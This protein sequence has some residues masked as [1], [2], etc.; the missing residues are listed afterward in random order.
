[1]IEDN[2][3]LVELMKRKE[4]ISIKEYKKHSINGTIR[5]YKNIKIEIDGIL[6]DSKKEGKTYQELKLEEKAGIIERLRWGIK[7]SIDVNGVYIGY[8]KADFDYYRNNVLVI[9]DVKSE[10]TRKNS[11]YRLKKK[12]IKAIYGI[13]IKE[14]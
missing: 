10:I 13:E 1:M 5:K 14:T 3:K 9:H 6:F 7:Y 12:L 8:Y 11:T 4:S 2:A